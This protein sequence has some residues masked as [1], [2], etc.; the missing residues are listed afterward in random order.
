MRG[1]ARTDLVGE[2]RPGVGLVDDD[3]YPA[4]ARGEVGGQGNVASEASN[5]VGVAAPQYVADCFDSAEESG[6]NSRQLGCDPPGQRHRGDQGEVIAAL[7]DEARLETPLGAERGDL[8]A[9]II[10]SECVGKGES[11][12][13]VTGGSAARQDDVHG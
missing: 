12:L 11:R 6:R 9:W 10:E 3:G 13:D 2:P 7:P 8:H 4:T 5:D 1:K